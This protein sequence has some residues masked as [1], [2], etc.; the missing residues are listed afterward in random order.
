[1]IDQKMTRLER[2]VAYFL[3]C[4]T[5]KRIVLSF[6]PFEVQRLQ[7]K[8]PEEKRQGEK[9]VFFLISFSKLALG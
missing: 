1:M 9:K 6:Y 3:H 8:S 7:K 2:K 4:A 5:F